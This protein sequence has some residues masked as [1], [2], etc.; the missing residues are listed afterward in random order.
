MRKAISF[1]LAEEWGGEEALAVW[2]RQIE[3]IPLLR[4]EE[5][6]RLA[7]RI[8]G[9]DE[10]AYHRMV[11]S[12]L[13]LVLRV[14]R[15]YARVCREACLSLEDLVQEGNIGLMTAARRF[16]YRKGYRFSTYALYWIHQAISRAVADKGRMIRLPVYVSEALSKIHQTTHQMAQ[17]LG[18]QP[19]LAEL[20]QEL[21]LPEAKLM[22]LLQRA[23][24]PLSFESSL[25]TDEG[26][27][28]LADFLPDKQAVGP[29]AAAIQSSL[30]E[31]LEW[32]LAR[33]PLREQRV[34]RMRYG[35]DDGSVHTLEEVARCLRLSRERVRQIE[36]RAL[37][38]LR[39]DQ[40][41]L[42]R[43]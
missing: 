15:K 29:E 5:E 25:D 14:A 17:R 4:P 9:G 41:V 23:A 20:A 42:I 43:L 37:E 35:L 22:V 7:Q 34:L 38:Q 21:H 39:Q 16:D 26:H 33:L 24:E 32:I 2:M 28:T 13:R 27:T 36:K 40:H 18:R 1:D 30:R 31:Q 12:N 10:T 11:E 8:E 19:T 3:G 6:V